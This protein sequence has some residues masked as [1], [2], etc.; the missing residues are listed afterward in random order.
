MALGKWIITRFTRYRRPKMVE[1]K[2]PYLAITYWMMF[3][4]VVGIYTGLYQL[5]YLHSY[6]I[7]E[8]PAAS[9]NL[10]I[11]HIEYNDAAYPE[12]YCDPTD[13]YY[14]FGE[15]MTFEEKM[16]VGFN[17]NEGAQ[18]VN[19]TSE[20]HLHLTASSFAVTTF[21]M[22]GGPADAMNL[23][24][25]RPRYF[26]R[27]VEGV[28]MGMGLDISTSWMPEA[29]SV[30]DIRLVTYDGRVIEPYANPIEGYYLVRIDQLLE[31]A[32]VDLDSLNRAGIAENP[33]RRMCGAS[34]S[35]RFECTNLRPFDWKH[36]DEL[37]CDMTV[38]TAGSSWGNIGSKVV[39]EPP[40]KDAWTGEPVYSVHVGLVFNAGVTGMLGNFQTQALIRVMV[41]ALVLLTTAG[42]LLNFV[43]EN[44]LP[45]SLPFVSAFKEQVR[46]R[47]FRKLPQKPEDPVSDS[48]ESEDEMSKALPELPTMEGA[49]TVAI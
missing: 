46:L 42:A 7:F 31:M 8:P 12:P 37:R 38:A 44:F 48:D 5:S 29:E 39:L 25:G 6:A 14:T 49:V 23:D 13:P 21:E 27:D 19:F 9:F 3:V 1:Y 34:L 22:V 26:V 36:Y 43:C 16:Q 24:H 35:L 28:V 17:L 40:E 18:C 2:D 4:F 33:A 32:G 41:D 47:I 20:R 45:G 11:N 10:W 30:K 15:S